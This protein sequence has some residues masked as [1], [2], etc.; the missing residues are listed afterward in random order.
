MTLRFAFS[1]MRNMMKRR[2]MTPK[3]SELRISST[4]LEAISLAATLKLYLV[5]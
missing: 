5:R 1:Q 3:D 4:R 2:K